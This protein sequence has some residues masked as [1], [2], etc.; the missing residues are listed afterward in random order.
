MLESSNC[1]KATFLSSKNWPAGFYKLKK[2]LKISA[3]KAT[4]QW[5]HG[6]CLKWIVCQAANLV[7][8]LCHQATWWLILTPVQQCICLP[9]LTNLVFDDP[10]FHPSINPAFSRAPTPAIDIL[11]WYFLNC[12]LIYQIP[13]SDIVL[14]PFLRV[15]WQC[16]VESNLL[17]HVFCT[18]T[19]RSKLCINLFHFEMNQ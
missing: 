19:N 4:D 18:K 14:G 1:R 16:Q 13:M 9:P 5:P 11:G 17:V 3:D 2:N 7:T 6:Y 8:R 12:V 10:H 15:S